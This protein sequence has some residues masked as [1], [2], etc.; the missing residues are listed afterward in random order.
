MPGSISQASP[1]GTSPR[2]LKLVKRPNIINFASQEDSQEDRRGVAQGIQD[3]GDHE[4]SNREE[5]TRVKNATEED[6]LRYRLVLNY[7]EEIREESRLL[8]QEENERKEAAMKKKESW[9]LMRKCIDLL[10]A[11]GDR[12]RERKIN[13]CD[14]IREEEKKDRLAVVRVKKRKYGLKRLSKEE[15]KR[16]TLRTE[17]R[18]EIAKAKENLW[19]QYRDEGKRQEIGKEEEDSWETLK[20]TLME[21]EEEDGGWKKEEKS[22]CNLKLR[23]ARKMGTDEEGLPGVTESKS[24]MSCRS[25]EEQTTG[26][27][28]DEEGQPGVMSGDNQE[29]LSDGVRDVLGLKGGLEG[30]Q[31]KSNGVN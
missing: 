31:E 24:S 13:E 21:L 8:M 9:E 19:R 28:H 22:L 3:Q 15:N 10:K 30:H 18:L 26:V 7:M 27:K 29:A 23:P 14:R 17:E 11:N 20:I 16:M 6:N 2:T 5:G 1:G 12:W 4:E 25:Q